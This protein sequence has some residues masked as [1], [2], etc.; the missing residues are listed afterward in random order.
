MEIHEF[1]RKSHL[2]R[3]SS[4]IGRKFWKKLNQAQ[5][6]IC[7]VAS[8]L[9]ILHPMASESK[10][11]FSRRMAILYLTIQ[12]GNVVPSDSIRI[13]ACK[14]LPSQIY[15]SQPRNLQYQTSESTLGKP[16]TS[17]DISSGTGDSLSHCTL[18]NF[19]PEKSNSR[20]TFTNFLIAQPI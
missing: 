18:T 7:H 3:G 8:Q 2:L 16:Q 12:P 5:S 9:K 11:N 4:T 17:Q 6:I 14:C 15:G 13:A 19:F 1:H 20:V 10:G